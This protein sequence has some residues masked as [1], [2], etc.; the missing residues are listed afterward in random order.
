MPDFLGAIEKAGGAGDMAGV[1]GGGDEE[2]KLGCGGDWGGDGGACGCGGI[3][4]G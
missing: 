1:N 3:G 4:V 2:I